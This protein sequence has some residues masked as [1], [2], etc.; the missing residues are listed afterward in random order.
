MFFLNLPQEGIRLC[1]LKPS[2]TAGMEVPHPLEPFHGL[3]LVVRKKQSIFF[4]VIVVEGLCLSATY[5]W[6]SRVANF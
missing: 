2:T 4:S 1:K 6:V 3:S 5:G